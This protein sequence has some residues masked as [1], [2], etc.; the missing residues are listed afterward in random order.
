MSTPSAPGDSRI[1]SVSASTWQTT[2]APV[3]LAAST[4]G[5][6]SSTV[7]RKFGCWRKTAEV[8]SSTAAAS[9]SMSVRPSSVSGVS[10]TVVP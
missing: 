5:P 4:S 1:P 9:A 3:F 6:R 2:I 7:P 8:S 10:T